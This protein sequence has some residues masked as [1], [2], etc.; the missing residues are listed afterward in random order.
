[1]N[2]NSKLIKNSML[3]LC[4][5]FLA[6]CYEETPS[7][8]LVNYNKS[9]PQHSNHYQMQLLFGDFHGLSTQTLTTNAIPLK[10]AVTA[11]VMKRN[12]EKNRPCIY[13]LLIMH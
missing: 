7:T 13:L 12:S 6:G 9:N 11:L 1:M 8:D 4:L 5:F 2:T 10:M 3:L